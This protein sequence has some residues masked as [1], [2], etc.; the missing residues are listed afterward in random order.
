MQCKRFEDS[1]V[2]LSVGVIEEMRHNLDG[3]VKYKIIYRD[4]KGREF[5]AWTNWMRDDNYRV[6]DS[7][8]VK[9]MAVPSFGL[10]NVP[11]AI[12]NHPQ[13][14]VEPYVAAMVLAGIGAMIAG[15]HIG[16]GKR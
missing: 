5:V 4:Y 1:P 13:R 14:Y 8:P 6:G 16:N 7:I 10:L 11:L 2:T 15:Y 3:L 12:N 9:N